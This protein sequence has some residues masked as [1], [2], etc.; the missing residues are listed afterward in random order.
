M[1]E[2]FVK[3]GYTD[4]WSNK[5]Y[6]MTIVPAGEGYQVKALYGRR[7]NVNNEARYPNNPVSYGLAELEF[8]KLLKKKLNKGYEIEAG[9]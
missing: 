8:Q 7:G 2:R 6:H 1:S 3:L 9:G 4:A 5:E